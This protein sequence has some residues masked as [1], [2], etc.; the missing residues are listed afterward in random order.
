MR[1]DPESHRV[2]SLLVALQF[3]L[4]AALIALATPAFASG[5]APAGAWL[6]ALGGL[7]LVG[8]AFFCNRPG[9]FNIHPAPR[10]GGRLVRH[11]PYRW[12]RHPM[13]TAVFCCAL[14]SAWASPS[15]WGWLGAAALVGV[16]A[17][18]ARLEERWMV[19][20]HAGYA[21]YQARTWRFVP[22]LY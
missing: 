22:G 5:R 1:T 15:R 20:A 21:D 11:G 7:L 14:S 6:L 3:S 9:N 18:K 4:I 12:V 2:G 19:E 10:A 16:L 8:W 17:T 13:Y